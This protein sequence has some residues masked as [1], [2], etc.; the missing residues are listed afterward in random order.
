M[1]IPGFAADASLYKTGGQYFGI[2]TGST[3]A[4]QVLPMICCSECPE[5]DCNP[6]DCPTGNPGCCAAYLKSCLA[7]RLQCERTCKHCKR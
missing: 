2:A 7:E 6:G 5:C 4:S 3:F 1:N